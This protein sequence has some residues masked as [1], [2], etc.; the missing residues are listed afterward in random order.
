M[1]RAVLQIRVKPKF[2]F[3]LGLLAQFLS[4]GSEALRQ[5]PFGLCH[6]FR[7]RILQSE[8]LLSYINMSSVGS[9]RSTGIGRFLATMD[10]S[11][12]Q[13]GRITV[14]YFRHPLTT[15]LPPRWVSQVPRLIFPRALSPTTPGGPMAAFVR[16][17]TTGGGLHHSLAGWPLSICVTRPNRVHLRY[18]SR[19]RST[20]LRPFGL[21]RGPPAP[22]PAERTI[23]RVTSFQVT[24]SARLSLAHQRTQRRTKASPDAPH[25]KR[26]L[27][28]D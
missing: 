15:L 22:L 17:F 26:F 21:L 9:L 14:M 2:R 25:L 5:C 19:V 12:S 8:H 11:D 16:F 7:H 4:Q 1:N 10:P 24:R 23:N 20:G 18:G 13:Q 3:L 27:F 28:P 6:F